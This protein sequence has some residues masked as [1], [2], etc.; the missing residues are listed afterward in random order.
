MCNA[1]AVALGTA[2]KKNKT[3]N[4]CTYNSSYRSRIVGHTISTSLVRAIIASMESFI[5]AK[6]YSEKA[7]YYENILKCCNI[8]D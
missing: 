7:I 5:D 2:A 6:K 8:G 4:S 3:I 1:A